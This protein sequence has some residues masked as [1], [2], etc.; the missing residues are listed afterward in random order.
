MEKPIPYRQ[1]L[2]DMDSPLADMPR[3]MPFQIPTGYFPHTLPNTLQQITHQSPA[4]T[5]TDPVAEIQALSPLLA[6]ADRSMPFSTPTDIRIPDPSRHTA[7]TS[8]RPAPR[9]APVRQLTTLRTAAAILVVGSATALLRLLTPTAP[10]TQQT[11]TLAQTRPS[12]IDSL[13]LDALDAYLHDT[14]VATASQTI[15]VESGWSDD[16][17]DIL[18]GQHSALDSSLSTLP[19]AT[20]LAYVS[21]TNPSHT[22]LR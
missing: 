13:A 10:D 2:Q 20:L 6:Q 9:P 18:L 17:N 12:D 15:G 1:E 22:P 3:D 8:P 5:T 4:S 19:D 7:P 21:E 11:I 16:V 14:D